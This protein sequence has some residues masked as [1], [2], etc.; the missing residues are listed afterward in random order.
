MSYEYLIY[1]ANM[2]SGTL[3]GLMKDYGKDIWNYAYFLTGDRH[4][5]DDLSQEVF[6]RAYRS[7][8]NFRGEA[9]VKTWLL[10]ITR[11]LALNHRRSAFIRRVT[12]LDRIQRQG[13]VRSAEEAFLDAEVADGIWRA[14]LRLPVPF[15]EVLLLD[16][17][18]GMSMEEIAGMLHVSVGTVKSRLHRARAKVTKA[19]QEEEGQ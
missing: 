19:L 6:L 18:H 5:A 2:D 17:Q 8:G 15:R 9:T 13:S 1:T 14:V 10:R 16:M 7:I 3:D 11:N 4:A 12:L